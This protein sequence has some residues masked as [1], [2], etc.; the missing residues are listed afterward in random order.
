VLLNV[1]VSRRIDTHGATDIK[2]SVVVRIT[3]AHNHGAS[4]LQ[5]VFGF[6]VHFPCA[7]K[8][9]TPVFTTELS[10]CLV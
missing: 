5:P 4:V 8:P 9:G 6:H 2:A 10:L 7:M 1:L 3:M